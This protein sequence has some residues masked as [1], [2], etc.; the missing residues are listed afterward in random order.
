MLARWPLGIFKTNKLPKQKKRSWLWL[1]DGSCV[2]V[3]P[4][5]PSHV[6]SFDFLQDRTQTGR[7]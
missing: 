4:E 5:R 7:A 1:N 3:Q 6:W 2:R